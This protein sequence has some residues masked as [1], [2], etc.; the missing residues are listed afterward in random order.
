[1]TFEELQAKLESGELDIPI[2]FDEETGEMV[3]DMEALDEK[4]MSALNALLAEAEIDLPSPSDLVDIHEGFGGG[5]LLDMDEEED[6]DLPEF[7]VMAL[8]MSNMTEERMLDYITDLVCGGIYDM[9][10]SAGPG[11]L[12][13]MGIKLREDW[14]IDWLEVIE[15]KDFEGT[16]RYLLG[17]LPPDK[18]RSV[19]EAA[20]RRAVLIMISEGNEFMNMV[21]AQTAAQIVVSNDPEVDEDNPLLM[22]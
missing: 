8:M 12:H 14:D 9:V 6:D 16:V 3:I 22:L 19:A 5:I 21:M 17:Q 20:F 4:G 1:M 15:T 13:E 18:L 7:D 2:E 11:A 10:D